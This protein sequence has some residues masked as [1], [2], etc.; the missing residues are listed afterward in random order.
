[1][2]TY[3]KKSIAAILLVLAIAAGQTFWTYTGGD[4]RSEDVV[5]TNVY[6][7]DTIV[8][9]RGW[10][11]TTVRLIGVDTPETARPDTPVQFYGP[12]AADF[13]RRSLEGTQVRLEFEAPDRAGGSVDRYGRTLAYV[14]LGDAQNFNLELV[15]LGYGRVFGKYPFR[16]QAEFRKAE[17]A[18]KEAGLGIWNKSARAAWADPGTRGRIIGNIT[19]HIYHSPGQYGYD[20]VREKN[21]V[22]FDTE[23][24]AR[25]AGFRRAKN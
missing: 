21:R 15:R 6:D 11:R 19:S 9:G 24:E 20:R 18:A 12:E 8:V 2:R 14:T 13:T 10:R 5:V 23:E 16:Y 22:Y 17:R 3:P 1:M 4:A 25:K 7:G